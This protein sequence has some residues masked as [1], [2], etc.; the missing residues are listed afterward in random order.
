MS[1]DHRGVIGV[2]AEAFDERAVDL[3]VVRVASPE[4]V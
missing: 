2:A 1:G 4:V 3:E